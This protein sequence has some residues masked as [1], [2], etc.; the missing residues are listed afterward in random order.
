MYLMVKFMERKLQVIVGL[1]KNLSSSFKE[2][3]LKWIL[4]LTFLLV[5]LLLKIPSKQ[6]QN[7]KGNT[8]V[9]QFHCNASIF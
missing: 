3:E 2:L 4:E 1:G 7:S 8:A 9:Q 6:K 5:L